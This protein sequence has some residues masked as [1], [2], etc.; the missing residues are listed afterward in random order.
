MRVYLLRLPRRTSVCGCQYWCTKPIASHKSAYTETLN[1][2][3]TPI[4]AWPHDC[5]QCQTFWPL[6]V[7]CLKTTWRLLC[8]VVWASLYW[9]CHPHPLL[10][11]L[12]ICNNYSAV[13]AY[14]NLGIYVKM[15]Y[16][17][18]RL[19]FKVGVQLYTSFVSLWPSVTAP[20]VH[21]G[22]SLLGLCAWHLR[23]HYGDCYIY[24]INRVHTLR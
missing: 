7:S 21:K 13:N 9:Y 14:G 8:I 4:P 10:S 3:I 23:P 18:R 2:T 1:V 19:V 6:S 5:H 22:F 12:D 24:I 15:I 20:A 16:R 11:V 17:L